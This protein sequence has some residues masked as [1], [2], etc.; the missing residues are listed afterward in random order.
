MNRN[1]IVDPEGSRERLGRLSQSWKMVDSCKSLMVP[2]PRCISL[3]VEAANT[4]YVL[5]EMFVV[6]ACRETPRISFVTPVFRE[7]LL[8]C[9][10]CESLEGTI[11]ISRA[12]LG[13]IN[14]NGKYRTCILI[15]EVKAVP[16]AVAVTA[17]F[18]TWQR[19]GAKVVLVNRGLFACGKYLRGDVRLP[20]AVANYRAQRTRDAPFATFPELS[21]HGTRL[22]RAAVPA[23][24]GV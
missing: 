7:S 2:A 13:E 18:D 21:W 20:R 11:R 23:E 12:T 8:L 10:K 4:K 1:Q 5:Y 15:A 24:L 9:T 14:A 22:V 6:S 17:S 3:L 16:E 19:V